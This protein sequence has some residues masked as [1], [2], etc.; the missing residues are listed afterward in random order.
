MCSLCHLAQVWMHYLFST[1]S[2]LKISKFNNVN[3]LRAQLIFPSKPNFCN[4][5]WISSNKIHSKS[6]YLPQLSSEICDINFEH[7]KD[8]KSTAWSTLV[9]EI[10]AWQNKTNYDRCHK[11]CLNI[12][13]DDCQLSNITKLGKKKHC[14]RVQTNTY[15]NSNC[16]HQKGLPILLFLGIQNL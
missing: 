12:L 4:F 8:T 5:V 15:T 10:P 11:I 3:T 7:S 16:A 13:M 14:T 9:W 1:F 2:E 6:Q